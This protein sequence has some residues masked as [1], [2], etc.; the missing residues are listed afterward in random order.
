MFALIRS[1]NCDYTQ[2]EIRVFGTVNEAKA[3]MNADWEGSYNEL[4]A[5]GIGVNEENSYM[6]DDYACIEIEESAE[7]ETWT[8][9]PVIDCRKEK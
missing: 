2:S 6:E 8:I 4:V 5:Q 3:H 9:A 7:Q 1:N